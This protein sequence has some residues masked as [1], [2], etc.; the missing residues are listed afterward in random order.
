VIPIVSWAE[1]VDPKTLDPQ[2]LEVPPQVTNVQAGEE[3]SG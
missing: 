1:R 3:P 2:V